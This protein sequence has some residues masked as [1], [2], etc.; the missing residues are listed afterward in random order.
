MSSSENNSSEQTL[1]EW[2]LLVKAPGL[3]PVRIRKLLE[4][5]ITPAKILSASHKELHAC[6]IPQ[7]AIRWL[8][9]ARAKDIKHEL[10]WL[11]HENH[12]AITISADNYPPLLAELHDAPPLLFVKGNVALITSPQLAIVGS[13]HPSTNGKEHAFQFAQY[14]STS[15]LLITSGLAQGVDA[16]SHQGALSKGSTIAV[17]ATGLDRVYPAN[18]HKLAHQIS[19]NGALVSEFLPGTEARKESFPRRNRLI[20][21]LSLG[22]LVVEASLRSG[23]LITAQCAVEQGREVFAIPGSIHNPLSKGCHQLIKQGAKLVETAAD[24]IEE[25]QSHLQ[26]AIHGLNSNTDKPMSRAR[27]AINNLTPE[28]QRLL[29]NIGYSAISID[30]LVSKTGFKAAEISSMLLILELDGQIKPAGSGLYL[31]C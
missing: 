19:K 1:S 3:G 10:A 21:G 28:Y 24:V 20:S 31:R 29:E 14:L 27:S 17:C 2:I 8:K 13:R 22:T 16:Y 18:H 15:G 30:E 12:H 9:Q 7:A 6:K 25:L 23:S 5:F 11:A 4:K 26:A